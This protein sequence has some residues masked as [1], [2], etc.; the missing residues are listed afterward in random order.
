MG[1]GNQSASRYEAL[2]EEP[3]KLGYATVWY[4]W[5]WS[6]DGKKT[7]HVRCFPGAEAVVA[8]VTVGPCG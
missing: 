7:H 6:L 5:D 4:W 3:S 8:P 2:I 1:H